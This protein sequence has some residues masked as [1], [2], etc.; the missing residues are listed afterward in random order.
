MSAVVGDPGMVFL[1]VGAGFAGATIA[2]TLAEA[3]LQV[4][5]IDKRSHVGGNAHDFVNCVGERIHRY[6]PHLLHGNR[7]SPAVVFLSRFT[8]WT[9][10]E[11]RVRALLPDGTTTPLPV[12]RTTL[13]DIFNIHLD[14][15]E[16][17]SRFLDSIRRRIPKPANADDLF[18]NGVG[19][20]LADLLFRPYT[21]K[22]WGIEASELDVA[23][24]A[25]LPV[26]CNRDERYFADSFQALPKYGYNRLFESMLDHPN[27]KLRLNHSFEK[28]MQHHYKHCFLCIPIDRY[29]D[30][31][32]GVLPYRS[33]RF[34]HGQTIHKQAATVINFTDTA[35]YTRV[36]QWS[37]LPNSAISGNGLHTIT[38][39]EP[40]SMEDNPGEYYYPVQ[41]SESQRLYGLYR[42]LAANLLDVSFCGRTGLFR[43][44]DMIP[45]VTMHLEIAERF[46]QQHGLRSAT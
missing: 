28:S 8:S 9:P 10:Y 26:R 12:N 18:L 39:E 43:Y 2:R 14:E 34:H 19:E 37:L 5:I 44:I 25:R 33:I 20:T 31:V 24:G 38:K 40:C 17:A 36:T 22:M 46:L 30:Y 45:A 21:R 41:T 35:P 32:Y 42:Q 13:E 11:H 4:D 15:D 29:F 7:L 6:G 23:I 27:I 1:V 3:G 16:S